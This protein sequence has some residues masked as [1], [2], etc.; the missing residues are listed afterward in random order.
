MTRTDDQ[1]TVGGTAPPTPH[2][3]ATFVFPGQVRLAVT[4]GI[5]VVA[6]LGVAWSARAADDR[7]GYVLAHAVTAVPFLAGGAA[8]A[9]RARD[10]GP[11]QFRAFWHRWTAACLVAGAAAFAAVGA[12]V[13]HSPV[14]L[15]VDV[16]L[17]VAAAPVWA[18]ASRHML[19]AQAGQRDPSVDLID[20]TMALVVLSAPVVLFVVDAVLRSSE[21]MFAVPFTFF[22]VLVPAGVYIALVNLA[23]V[24]AGERVT[25]GLGVGLVGAFSVGVALQ[26]AHVAAGLELPLPVFV[27]VHVLNLG[28]IMALP[29]WAHRVTAGGLGRLPVER[30][31]RERHLMPAVS[32][33]ALPVLAVYVLV[34]R[35]GDGWPVPYLTGVLLAVIALN[36]VRH[37]LL[38]REARRL[39]SRLAH[40]AEERRRLLAGM[41][42]ALDDDRRRSVSELHTQAIGSL[43]TLGTIVQTACVSLP[44]D[45]AQVVRETIGRLQGDLTDRAEHL[46]RLLV[47]MRTP[48]FGDEGGHTGRDDAGDGALG[49]AL[50]AYAADLVDDSTSAARPSVE[51]TVDPALELDRTTMTI[52]YR[53]AQEALLNATRHAG[54]TTVAVTVGVDDTG[55]VVLEV[56]DDG[57]GFD[58]EAV[59]EGSG[60]STM[61]LFT[62]LG[63]GEL[64]LRS[65]P[66]G[67]TLVRARLGVGRDRAEAG[68]QPAPGGIAAGVQH[69]AP[70]VRA[71]GA[72][73]RHLRLLPSVGASPGPAAGE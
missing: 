9:W 28:L 5:V 44:T 10:D 61:Q 3:A 36:A 73:R 24:P 20:S 60:V 49:A 50:R 59:T 45:T 23:R 34:W 71:P 41:V 62:S 68:R 53:I 56:A 43:S 39:S 69:G 25:Q 14:L 15:A 66:G 8:L 64:T 42:R 40:M 18:S 35:S 4:A 58:P 26:L 13:L 11:P 12:V 47:A 17:L 21:L 48:A 19:R 63:R 27:G 16:A 67:G 37:A 22:L 2:G 51:V 7:D 29:L 31:V 38:S 33:V 54:A 6:V 55:A 72:R 30:Q 1:P 65:A 52:V 70:A 32:A 57:S 46:R